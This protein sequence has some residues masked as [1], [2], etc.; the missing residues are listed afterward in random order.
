MWD[1]L[2]QAPSLNIV[3]GFCQFRHGNPGKTGN[4]ISKNALSTNLLSGGFL[5]GIYKVH[6]VYLNLFE[7]LYF[8]KTIVI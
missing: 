2:T 1:R 6:T 3:K 4:F 8:Q 5:D 7:S